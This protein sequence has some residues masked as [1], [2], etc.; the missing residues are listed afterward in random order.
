M[1]IYMPSRW[2]PRKEEIAMLKLVISAGKGLYL[3]I[4]EIIYQEYMMDIYAYTYFRANRF[5]KQAH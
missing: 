3:L 5:I 4:K 2:K 1:E